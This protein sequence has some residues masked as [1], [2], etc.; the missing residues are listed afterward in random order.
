MRIGAEINLSYQAWPIHSVMTPWTDYEVLVVSDQFCRCV[1]AKARKILDR[2]NLLVIPACLRQ[3]WYGY[4][5]VFPFEIEVI[6][7]VV[8]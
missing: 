6:C 1:L 2:T 3:C 7:S 4:P 5:L 8:T